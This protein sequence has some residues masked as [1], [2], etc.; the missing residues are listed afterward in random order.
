MPFPESIHFH[1]ERIVIGQQP[2]A[3]R[4]PQQAPM[5]HAPFDTSSTLW[6]GFHNADDLL[7]A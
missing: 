5:Y 6:K 4:L 2:S 7:V 1:D 3:L